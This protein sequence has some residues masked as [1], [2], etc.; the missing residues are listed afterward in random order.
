MPRESGPEREHFGGENGLITE[1][2]NGESKY[3]WRCVHCRYQLGGKIF[4]T[5][6][7]RIHLSGNPYLRNGKIAAVCTAAPADVKRKFQALVETKRQERKL[8]AQKRKRKAQLLQSKIVNSPIKQTRLRLA[9]KALESDVVN[10]TWGVA[11]F[12]LDIPASK[13]S[14]PLFREAIAATKRSKHG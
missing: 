13:I 1:I 6:K 11:F 12:G 3:F 8:A 2:V 10:D 9:P 7:A 4:H 14:H 5:D